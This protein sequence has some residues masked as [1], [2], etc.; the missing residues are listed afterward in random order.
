MRLGI[1]ALL[2][3]YVLSQ[4]YRAFLAVLTPV[5]GSDLGASASDLSF[6]SGIWF[7]VFACM[8]IPV[9]E[10]LDRFGP[11]ITASVLLAIGGGG[12]AALF[13]SASSASDIT[14]AMAL[15]GVGGAPVLMASYYIFAR[16]FP[17][18]IFAT[19]AGAMIGAGSLG[20]LASS[21]PLAF[22]VN[23][24]GWRQ[25]MWG[26]AIAALAVAAAIAL[27]VRDPERTPEEAGQGG[28]LL[29]LLTNRNVLLL[30]PF[31]LVNYAPAAALRG[32]WAGPYFE[33]VFAMDASGIGRVTLIMALA[34]AV[35]SFLY[36]PLERLAGSKKRIIM[37]GGTLSALSLLALWALPAQ[38]SLG[39]AALFTAVGLTGVSFP[40]IMAHGQLFIPRNLTGRGITLLNLFGIGGVGAMQFVTS[41]MA[42][43]A[44]DA[45]T[46]PEFYGSLF[47]LFAILVAVGL[48]FYAFVA[49]PKDRG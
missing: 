18:A 17:Q 14:W 46:T 34:M 23:A 7:I 31:M 19:L 40:V 3:G 12:G 29:S 6:S 30:V 4:F 49:E 35:G 48:S 27:F 44:A 15:F 24:I 26:L 38:S 9:G 21:A 10:A 41:A 28:N 47:L 39:S 45:A 32:L 11:R 13:A 22:A 25:T 37:A 5:L 2:L 20:N 36:G 42:E 33:D 43:R 1:F 16:S 8:Q